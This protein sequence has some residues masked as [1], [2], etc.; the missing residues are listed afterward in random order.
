MVNHIN[1]LPFHINTSPH[2]I[3]TGPGEKA[4][5]VIDLKECLTVKSA[6]DKV[7]KRYT[8]TN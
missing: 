6:E 8:I 7:N 1:C 5:G 4:H 3:T 2:H